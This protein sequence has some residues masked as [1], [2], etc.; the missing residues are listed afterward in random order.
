MSFNLVLEKVSKI[1]PKDFKE[2][3][4]KPGVP[5]IIQGLTEGTGA[6]KKWTIDYFKSTMGHYNVPL[7]DSR[8]KN[9][10][11]A[12]T[13][14]NLHMRF[15]DFLDQISKNEE[16]PYRMFLFN[17]FKLN[18]SLEKDFPCPDLARGLLKELGYMF[19]AGKGTKVRNHF[20]LDM[21][22]VFHTHFCGR[23]R[24]LLCSPEYSDF[25]YKLPLNSYS[26][27]DLDKPD[28]L[29]YPAAKRIQGYESILQEGETLFIPSGYWHYITYLDPGFS[30][31]YRKLPLKLSKKIEGILNITLKLWADKILAAGLGQNWL[32]WKEQTASRRA[33]KIS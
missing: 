13:Q 7:Y 1:S 21:G 8:I 18:P 29:K 4:L 32:K 25:L 10:S 9:P 28:Y 31:S 3:F 15:G 16:T 12:Y 6:A 2:E 20:D 26:L 24:I 22:N 30:V 33:I 27:V 17:L 5:V 11:S 19:F 23:K 14:P